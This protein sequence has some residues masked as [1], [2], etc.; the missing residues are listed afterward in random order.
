MD[1][2]QIENQITNLSEI[3]ARAD[4]TMLTVE[5]HLTAGGSL[6]DL[7]KTWNVSYINLLK[8]IRS[9][10]QRETVY[11]QA[12]NDRN[13]WARELVLNELFR[14]THGSSAELLDARGELIPPTEWTEEQKARVESI[15]IKTYVDKNG[16]VTNE[17]FVK[18]WDKLKA[19][20]LFGKNQGLFQDVLHVKGLTLEDLVQGS[21]DLDE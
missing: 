3:T 17:H 7:A 6:I 11:N 10:K 15:R 19:I 4:Q 9:D 13:E 20:T 5:S 21:K 14:L 16:E 8:W 12:M 2:K 1:N 18:S